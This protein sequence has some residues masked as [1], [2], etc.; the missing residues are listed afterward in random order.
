MALKVIN[1]IS[2]RLRFLYRKNRYLSPH[3]KRLLCN[4]II[5]PYFDYACSAWY[6]NP[7]KKFKS[8]LQTIQNKCIRFCLQ[9]NIRSHIGIK[10][11]EQINWLPFYERFNQC[12]CSN[13]FKFF[14]DNCHLYVYDLSKPSGQDQINTSPHRNCIH[15][16]YKTCTRCIQLMYT[17]CIPYFDQ[18]LYTF[19][20]QNQKNYS[21]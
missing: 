10:E 18:L 12:I 5:Q 15:F 21:S 2:S 19:C 13:A 14:N 8:K 11:S 7:N 1:K 16:V 4:A 3:L 9:L 6:P 17:K 20:I